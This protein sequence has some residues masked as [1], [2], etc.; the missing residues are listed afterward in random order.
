M[1]ISLKI[2]ILLLFCQVAGQSIYA[3]FTL[4]GTVFDS[5][6]INY[7]P[8]VTV[9]NKEGRFTLTDS[10]GRYSLAV[11]E[12]DSVS[13]IFRNKATQSF[14]VHTIPDPS[15][16]DISLRVNYKGKYSTLKEVVVFG[17]T[18]KQDSIEN[19]E[20]YAKVFDFQKPTLRTS[21]S[22]SGVP[23]A[24]V[25]EII[26]IFRF[27]RNKRLKSFQLRLEKDE[28]EKYINFRF[29]KTLVKKLTHLEEGQQLD[30]FMAKYRPTYEFASAADELTM[31]QYILNCGYQYKIELLQQSA[32]KEKM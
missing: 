6:K 12:K 17:K 5:S 3:Q 27:K 24:D 13:F 21:I 25:D 7:V 2:I 4:S 23:G 26:N 31:N 20:T 11:T 14:A 19:R 16:F 22:P 29:N 9:I 1:R 32:P 28:Q 15:H 30:N 10:L 8:G 18:F